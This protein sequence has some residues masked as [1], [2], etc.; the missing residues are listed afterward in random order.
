MPSSH[1]IAESHRALQHDAPAGP[2]RREQRDRAGARGPFARL[3]RAA[4]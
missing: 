1:F 2:Q 4:R 3:R